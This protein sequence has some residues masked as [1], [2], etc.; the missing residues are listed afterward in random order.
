MQGMPVSGDHGLSFR[1]ARVSRHTK[2][3]HG[4]PTISTIYKPFTAWI[5]H[6]TLTLLSSAASTSGLR[7]LSVG[8]Y[9]A[10]SILPSDPDPYHP[11]PPP[12]PSFFTTPSVDLPANL[13]KYV[14]DRRQTSIAHATSTLSRRS[15]KLSLTAPGSA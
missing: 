14:R 6:D 4:L 15:S 1:D 9:R 10:L 8:G 12:R 2:H 7:A 13:L 11:S 5:K 3:N